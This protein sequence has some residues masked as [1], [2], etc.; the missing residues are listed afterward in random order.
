[1]ESSM[2]I[3]KR[4]DGTTLSNSTVYLS[5]VIQVDQTYDFYQDG[6]ANG[7]PAGN[8]V[9]DP[10]SDGV[11]Y[12]GNNTSQNSSIHGQLAEIII[13][14]HSLGSL[15]PQDSVRERLEG[16]LAHKWGIESSLP[17]DHT[18]KSSPPYVS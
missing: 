8:N 18:Y 7:T 1:M 12:I 15:I 5:S 6:S 9:V 14:D 17:A 16:Y 10:D 4:G 13:I 3:D 2:A 11:L